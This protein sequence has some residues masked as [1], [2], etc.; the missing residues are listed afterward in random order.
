M[1]EVQASESISAEVLSM[2]VC[3]ACRHALEASAVAIRCTGC[4]RSYPV[5]DGIPV[6]LIER[7]SLAKPPAS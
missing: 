6:L 7:A 5:V 1:A 2:L 3:P 4:G